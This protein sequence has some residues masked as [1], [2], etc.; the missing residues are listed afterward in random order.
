MNATS[1]KSTAETE[2]VLQRLIDLIQIEPVADDRFRGQ[3]ENIGTPSVYGGQVLGQALM[4]AS[5]TAPVDR[6][7]H[8]FHA[9]FLLPG[10]HEPIDY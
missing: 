8:S 5:M 3:S 6:L 7:V 2:S 1:M 4:A 9:Y 10:R